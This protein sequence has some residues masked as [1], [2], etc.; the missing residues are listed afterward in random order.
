MKYSTF[1]IDGTSALSPDYGI[2]TETRTKQSKK[3]D[4]REWPDR[5]IKDRAIRKNV[6]GCEVTITFKANAEKT[7]NVKENTLWLILEA[8]KERIGVEA[9]DA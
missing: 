7:A 2:I 5:A 3:I 4:F 6:F 8:F 1:T 9:N